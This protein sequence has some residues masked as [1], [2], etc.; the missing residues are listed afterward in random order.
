[1]EGKLKGTCENDRN[2]ANSDLYKAIIREAYGVTDVIVGHHIVFVTVE[3]RK[4]EATGIEFDYQ[5]VQELASADTLLFDH[6]VAERLW[7]EGYLDV[8]TRLAL[9]PV[10]SRDALLKKLYEGRTKN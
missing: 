9:T 4:D 5:C 6:E 10:A 1:M 7:G 8:L 2:A 3:T